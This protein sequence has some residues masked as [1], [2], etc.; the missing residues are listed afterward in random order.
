MSIW[1]GVGFIL[2]DMV[3]NRGYPYHVKPPD[4]VTTFTLWITWLCGW[5][6]PCYI[7]G[8]IVQLRFGWV[9]TKTVSIQRS[10]W[11]PAAPS[12]S[13]TP[14][15][16]QQTAEIIYGTILS[17]TYLA[18]TELYSWLVSVIVPSMLVGVL[19]KLISIVTIA[20]A[21][22][23]AAFESKLIVKRYNIDSRIEYIESRWAYALGYGLTASLAYN[24]LP[25]VFA[26]GVWQFLQLLLTLRALNLSNIPKASTRLHFFRHAQILASYLVYILPI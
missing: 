21:T 24:C 8:S 11:V 10:L 20:W 14:R 23:F 5:G 3:I 7:I 18:Q 16:A 15:V 22:S 17:V 12:H 2:L 1:I 25:Y 9:V 19:I 26:T 13:L 6:I 4:S